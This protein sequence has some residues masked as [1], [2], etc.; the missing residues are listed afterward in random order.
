MLKLVIG[1]KKESKSKKIREIRIGFVSPLGKKR[2]G[3]CVIVLHLKGKSC[4]TLD[5][6]KGR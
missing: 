4:Q 5:N 2:E 3:I 6:C 1:A